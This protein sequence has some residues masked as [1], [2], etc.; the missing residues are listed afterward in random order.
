MIH[1]LGPGISFIPSPILPHPL[2]SPISLLLYTSS[3][4]VIWPS[5]RAWTKAEN[6]ASYS[7]DI[8]SCFIG[9]PFLNG[10]RDAYCIGS[11]HLDRT[12]SNTQLPHI[13]LHI[14]HSVVWYFTP[15]FPTFPFF[16]LLLILS[17]GF[18]FQGMY[19]NSVIRTII[20]T[21]EDTLKYASLLPN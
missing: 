4:T 10:S 1:F 20:S 13:P 11:S 6:P 16:F 21:W 5:F 2:S 12:V 9:G 14:S 18:S 7:Q 19:R 15:C 17:R 8:L 3:H